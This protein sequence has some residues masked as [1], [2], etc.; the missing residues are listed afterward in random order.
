VREAG[1][2]SESN[3]ATAQ[4]LNLTTK[5]VRDY[6]YDKTRKAARTASIKLREQGE[7]QKRL[8]QAKQSR[9]G[10][11]PMILHSII[12]GKTNKAAFQK[13]CREITDP[14]TRVYLTHI[15][16]KGTPPSP[17]GDFTLGILRRALGPIQ[18]KQ[19][20]R[21]HSRPK[22]PG[23]SAKKRKAER[24]AYFWRVKQCYY[25]LAKCTKLAKEIL[26]DKL[27]TECT[28]GRE[29]VEAEFRTRLET[30]SHPC[31][32]DGWRN[33]SPADNIG[34]VQPITLDDLEFVIKRTK[35]DT[36]PGPDGVTLQKIK[37][38]AH[39][40][41]VDKMNVWLL[42]GEV[43]AVFNEA[44]TVLIP[45]KGDLNQIRNWRPLSIGH[46]LNRFFCKILAQ[47]LGG[48]VSTHPRQKGFSENAGCSDN[49]VLLRGVISAKKG[50]HN[51]TLSF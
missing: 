46:L 3:A 5:Q 21:G 31:D 19:S 20:G 24:R 4:A 14:E 25:N 34:I 49:L 15:L 28:I 10:D 39:H 22:A 41:L 48:A 18:R 7:I 36:A 43:P 38:S 6:R 16:E 8:E 17:I 11:Q 2:S 35:K 32:L 50:K 23:N 12:K 9:R 13:V 37:P 26:D 30:S 42:A 33:L 44:R 40:L 29:T 45:K 27:S 51:Y 47:R 1:L